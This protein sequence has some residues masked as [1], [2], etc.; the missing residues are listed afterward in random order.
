MLLA[1][2]VIS[3]PSGS[4]GPVFVPALSP[5]IYIVASAGTRSPLQPFPFW[6]MKVGGH[7]METAFV[8]YWT[9]TSSVS[10]LMDE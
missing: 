10:L 8:Y 2:H 5:A 9:L 6:T 7:C 4:Q 1:V 3:Y